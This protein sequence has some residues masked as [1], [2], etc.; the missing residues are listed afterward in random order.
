VG[1]YTCRTWSWDRLG[2]LE[3]CAFLR[4][5]SVS[6][7]MSSLFMILN[8]KMLGSPS[9]GKARIVGSHSCEIKCF[10]SSLMSP[11][12]GGLNIVTQI[13]LN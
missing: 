1:L 8:K 11:L 9:I 12:K 5:I 3:C 7:V 2:L 4:G 13:P 10:V 6:V